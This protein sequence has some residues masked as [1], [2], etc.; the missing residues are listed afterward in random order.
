MIDLKTLLQNPA[1]ALIIPAALLAIMLHELSHGLAAYRLGDNTAKE[2]GRLSLNPI[3]HIDIV[4]LLALIFAGFGWAKPVPVDMRYF[5]KPRRDFALVAL[6][7]PVSNFL[8]A[9]AGFILFNAACLLHSDLREAGPA[10]VMAEL[11]SGRFLFHVQQI[12]VLYLHLFLLYYV[13][14]NVGLGVF[15]LIPIPPLDGSK[16][17][18]IVIPDRY[19]YPILKYEQFGMLLL[20]ALLFLGVLD[21]PLYFLQSNVRRGIGWL[22]GLPFQW[23]GVFGS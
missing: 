10:V 11:L 22:A 21:A 14:C 18:G 1:Q 3:R 8:Q 6:A 20:V 5:K 19:Y 15:N 7:G 12:P 9:L 23:L 16:I 17:V 13:M 4:G 2:K